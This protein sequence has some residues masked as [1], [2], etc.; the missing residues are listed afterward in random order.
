MNFGKEKREYYVLKPVYDE[1]P[2]IYAPT[3]NE[4]VTQKMRRVLTKDEIDSLI[5]SLENNDTKWSNNDI[6][7]KEFCAS[8][9]EKGDRKK[10]NASG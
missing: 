3:D 6:E 5:E 7:R 1:N 4:T 2:T 10:V 8:V 9:I